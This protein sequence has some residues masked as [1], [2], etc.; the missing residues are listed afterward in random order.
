MT[1]VSSKK[2][3]ASEIEED[4]YR[5]L[6]EIAMRRGVRMAAVVEE[7]V[8][9]G[10]TAKAEGDEF[11]E[12]VE[13]QVFAGL[14]QARKRARVRSMLTQ[15]AYEH[16]Q[17]PGEDTADTLQRLCDMAGIPVEDIVADSE[18]AVSVP[19]VQDTGSGLSSALRWLQKVMDKN[20][21]YPVKFIM[22]LAQDAGFSEATI[23]SA[24]QKL[25]IISKRRSR[26]WVWQRKEMTDHPRSE[27][28][29]VTVTISN[30]VQ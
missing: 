26:E 30:I 21:E 28:E 17:D 10:I 9:D 11:F 24:K 13:V 8:M 7:M 6:V 25:L 23:K 22:N 18:D 20:V 2:W 29:P 14:Y 12:T 4:A 16:K 3:I 1:Y 19:V 15:I 5:A 27:A